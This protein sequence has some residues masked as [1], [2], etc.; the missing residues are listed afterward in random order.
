MYYRTT[1][2]TGGE[3]PNPSCPKGDI[4]NFCIWSATTV[5]IVPFGTETGHENGPFYW[6]TNTMIDTLTGRSK[7]HGFV[8]LRSRYVQLLD[9][10]LSLHINQNWVLPWFLLV[11]LYGVHVLCGLEI[12]PNFYS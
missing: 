8:H 5:Q 11:V 12:D 4:E 9:G 7:L 2:L 1:L 10:L 3:L 6:Y